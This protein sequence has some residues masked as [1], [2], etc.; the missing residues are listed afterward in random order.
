MTDEMTEEYR[1]LFA[2]LAKK[3]SYTVGEATREENGTYQVV[4]TVKPITL[5]KDTYAEFQ[6]AYGLNGE[7][8]Q[9]GT[10]V[11]NVM[12]EY[13]HEFLKDKYHDVDTFRKAWNDEKV[14]FDNA[15]FH[16]EIF[17]PGDD[18]LFRDPQKSR[19]IMDAQECIQTS[20]VNAI[21]HFCKI[22]KEVMGNAMIAMDMSI[23]AGFPPYGYCSDSSGA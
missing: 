4:L 17:T 2:D 14:T 12:Q 20:N 3:T 19:Y 23:L 16:P 22:V 11:S 8:H 1:E 6:V 10:D 15:P 9:I 18:G 13:F 5:L 21:V 7:W